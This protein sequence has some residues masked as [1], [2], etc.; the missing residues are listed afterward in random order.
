[1]SGFVCLV[2]VLINPSRCVNRCDNGL[3][4]TETVA[5]VSWSADFNFTVLVTCLLVPVFTHV[6]IEMTK[7]KDTAYYFKTLALLTWSR[8]LDEIRRERKSWNA[9]LRLQ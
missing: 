7:R 9:G 4:K 8:S 1:M 3:R 6:Y 5:P 2:S